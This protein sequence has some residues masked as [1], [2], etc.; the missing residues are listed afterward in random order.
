MA[1][2]DLIFRGSQDVIVK[3]ELEA[4]LDSKTPMRIKFG[5]D[6][7]AGRIHIG[8]AATIR[9]LKHFQDLGHEVHIIIGDFTGQIGD[10]SDKDVERKML[11]RADIEENMKNYSDQ[12]SKI[13]DTSKMTVHYNGDWFYKMDLAEFFTLQQMFSVAQMIERDNF[14]IR[15]EKGSRIGLH[16][17]S[18]ALLQGYDSV[19]MKADVEIGGTDQLFNLLAGRTV[20]KNYDLKQQNIVTYELLLGLD[21]R[22]MS[23][24]W[25]NCI[26][27][28]DEPSE[29]F[30]KVMSLKDELMWDYFRIVTEL[31][32]KEL[33]QIKKEID[34]G[35]DPKALKIKLASEITKMYHGQAFA[36][37]AAANFDS[38]FTQG[39][40]PKDV[41]DFSTQTGKVNVLDLVLEAGLVSSRSDAKRMLSQDAIKLNQEKVTTERVEISDGD[42]I[43]VGKRRFCK[44]K[45]Q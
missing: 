7:T 22:K 27:V 26:Y 4:R 6:P 10:S 40:S 33:E 1:D 44:V 2:T 20:Q 19:A 13:F 41:E 16:E 15:Y 5:I 29:M 14:A 23:T 36:D 35:A 9:H 12:L 45:G 28:D 18:Y 42:I 8:R 17:F 39:N 31:S 34:T 21:G 25:D 38:Q 37:S 32:T 30:G 43:Q 11:S 24:T 3:E